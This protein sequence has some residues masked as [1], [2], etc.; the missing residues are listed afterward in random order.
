ML[1]KVLTIAILAV[2]PALAAGSAC[3]AAA[4]GSASGPATGTATN[5][6]GGNET[7]PAAAPAAQSG[8]RPAHNRHLNRP[9]TPSGGASNTAAPS[10]TP[11]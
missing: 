3:A 8:T 10:P 2:S 7:V 4:T 5:T 11:Q 9:K 1:A 6:A